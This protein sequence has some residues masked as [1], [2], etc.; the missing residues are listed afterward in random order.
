MRPCCVSPSAPPS[1]P[2]RYV[3]RSMR[4]AADPIRRRRIDLC[5]ARALLVRVPPGPRPSLHWLRHQL[6]GF[7]RWLRCYYGGV[8]LLGFVHHRLQLLVFPMRTNGIPPLAEPKISRF[9]H[10]ERPHMPGS[11][12]TPGWASARDDAPVH[13][14]FRDSDHVGTRDY[15]AFAAPWLA[16][17]LLYRRFTDA[18]PTLSRVPAHGSGPM[19][20]AAPSPW[21]TFTSYSLPVLIGAPEIKNTVEKLVRYGVLTWYYV[22]DHQSVGGPGG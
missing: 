4:R 22:V 10:K 17:A 9:P 20:F 5:P 19:R 8:R 3:R 12:T 15:L 11:P 6:P 13:F 14:A 1:W 7:V 2:R 18:S 16:Y 21:G